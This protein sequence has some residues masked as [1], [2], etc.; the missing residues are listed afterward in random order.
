MA[1]ASKAAIKYAF[2][3]LEIKLLT[4]HHYTYNHQSKRVIEKCGFL[5]EGTLRHAA[6]IYDGSI[7]DLAC[8]SMTKEEWENTL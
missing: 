2:E 3:N 1:E 6:K 8:Y 7:Y 4:V 5:Y